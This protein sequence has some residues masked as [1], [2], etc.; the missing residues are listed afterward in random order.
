MA[1]FRLNRFAKKTKN[2]DPFTVFN[3]HSLSPCQPSPDGCIVITTIDPGIKN[4]AIRTARYNP[5]TGHSTT[6]IQDKFNFSP[7]DC[8]THYYVNI[9]DC[10]DPLR[11]Y[12]IYS[13]Y[14]GIESQMAFNYDLVRMSQHLI[15]YLMCMIRNK[16]NRPLI[17]ELDARIKTQFL[18]APKKMDKPHRKKWAV[19]VAEQM[20]RVDGEDELADSLRKGKADD[21]GDTICYE[22]CVLLLMLNGKINAPS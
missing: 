4:C 17:L 11:D 6:L 18:N 19:K 5:L 16:G 13:H 9:F 8:Q 1:Y 10:L 3:P 22:K 2:T 15:T 7:K 20:L 21:H 12:F 14:I